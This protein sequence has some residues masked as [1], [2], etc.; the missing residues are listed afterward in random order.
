[1][2]VKKFLIVSV[3][4]ITGMTVL[5]LLLFPQAPLNAEE[6]KYPVPSY[7]GDE[8]GK[9]RAW[10]KDWVGKKIDTSNIDQVKEFMP[11]NLYILYKDTEKSGKVWFVIAP[12]R[13]IKP[14]TGMI[15]ATMSHA[16][17]AKI[18]PKG[19]MLNWVSGLPFPIPTTAEEIANNFGVTENHGDNAFKQAIAQVVDG[20]RKYD[21]NVGFKATMMWFCGRTEVPPIPEIEPNTKGI[22]RAHQ[23]EWVDPP[24]LRGGRILNVKWKDESKD[25]GL[26]EF[27]FGTRRV[28]RKS[29]ASRQ[30][31]RGGS[32]NCADD[33]RVYDYNISAQTYR[34]LG[35]KDLLLGRHVD[36]SLVMKNHIEGDI[37]N[38]GVPRERVKVYVIEAKHRDPNY[39]YSRQI[40]YIDP[41]TWNAIYAD[42]YD[43]QG[44]LWKIFDYPQ[45]TSKS[46]LTGEDIPYLSAVATIDVQR[47]HSTVGGY[48]NQ[49]FGVSGGDVYKPDYY[50]PDGLLKYGY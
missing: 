37:V 20:I 19:E 28:I 27:S 41:E 48:F 4:V 33:E 21:R 5:L 11:E 18:G 42:K 50:T 45:N 36:P 39:L 12:Y 17:T 23:F 34:D 46:V 13:E 8:L 14:T 44:K 32:D 31:M 10:E 26:W 16:G 29:T 47:N 1:M 22:R 15:K 38:S 9:L 49:S 3:K 24:A 40:Y 30:D 35:R 25:W 2:R 6:L 7:T 43:R